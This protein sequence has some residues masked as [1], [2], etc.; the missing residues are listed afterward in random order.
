MLSPRTALN[1]NFELWSRKWTDQVCGT[2]HC[3]NQTF[4][5]KQHAHLSFASPRVN[6][7]R[8]AQVNGHQC[9]TEEPER[10]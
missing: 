2:P 4:R 10:E 5:S 8:Q 1:L 7:R 3:I 9:Q 6:G